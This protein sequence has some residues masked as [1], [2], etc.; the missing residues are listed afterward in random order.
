MLEPAV[1]VVVDDMLP[2]QSFTHT[3]AII[4][5]GLVIIGKFL[6]SSRF[7]HK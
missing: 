6:L 2:T 3:R 7:I 1:Y 5:G 4:Q